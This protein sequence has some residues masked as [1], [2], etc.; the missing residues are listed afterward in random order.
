[1]THLSGNYMVISQGIGT[2]N[3]NATRVHK[4]LLFIVRV[5]KEESLFK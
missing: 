2:V 4:I 1:M 5:G 3:R